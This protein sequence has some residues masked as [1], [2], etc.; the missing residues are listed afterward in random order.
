MASFVLQTQHLEFLAFYPTA[1]CDTNMASVTK[2]SLMHEW[3]LLVIFS[4]LD[5]ENIR[6][7]I[8]VNVSSSQGKSNRFKSRSAQAAAMLVS[9]GGTS[10]WC[11]H[12][13]LYKFQS[14]VSANNSA[15]EYRTDRRLVN[16]IQSFKLSASFN[17]WFWG[18][19]AC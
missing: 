16:V 18:K 4:S 14:N 6:R 1:V 3:T 5:S 11:F 13:E 17:K 19:S 15:K 12:T 8:N 10:T 2:V 7:E 9:L